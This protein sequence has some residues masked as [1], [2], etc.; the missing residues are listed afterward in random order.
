MGLSSWFANILLVPSHYYMD[1]SLI[2]LRNK[3]F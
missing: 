2:Y 3:L 1:A